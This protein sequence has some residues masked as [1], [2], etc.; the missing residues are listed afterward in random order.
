[1][2]ATV[3]QLIAPDREAVGAI[4][5]ACSAFSEEEVR[6]AIEMVEAGLAGEYHLLGVVVDGTLRGYACSGRAPLT[7]DSWYLYWICVHPGHQGAG[8]GRMLQG[9]VEESIASFGGGR[10]VLET[11]GR[12][13][14]E[15]ARG[16]YRSQGF[17]HVGTIRNFYRAGDD[18]LIYCK[19]LANA[20]DPK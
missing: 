8:L 19:S 17:L 18:C 9:H 14:Y 7:V 10:I 15:C 13:D 20:G 2:G 5:A 1:M 11:S 6:V 12:P 4:L 3:R 16:F